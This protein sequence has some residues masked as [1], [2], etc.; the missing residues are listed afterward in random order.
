MLKT[1][2][3]R[4]KKGPN[5]T[6]FDPRTFAQGVQITRGASHVAGNAHGT[7]NEEMKD[8]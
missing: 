3:Q 4:K 5:V 8:E 2:R 7:I 6:Q 1:T